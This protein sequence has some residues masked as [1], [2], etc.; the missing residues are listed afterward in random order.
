MIHVYLNPTINIERKYIIEFFEKINTFRKVILT[1]DFNAHSTTWG[2]EI[3]SNVRGNTLDAIFTAGSWIICNDGAHTR[4]NHLSG[5]KSVPDI[6]VVTPVL[7]D[8]VAWQV[9][10]DP[11][12]S[13]HFP[14]TIKIFG[15]RLSRVDNLPKICLKKV[16]WPA[17]RFKMEQYLPDLELNKENFIEKYDTFI[18]KIYQATSFNNQNSTTSSSNRP[19]PIPC[20]WW[21]H[22]CRKARLQRKKAFKFYQEVPSREI[23]DKYINTARETQSIFQRTK[24]ES[25]REF[26]KT[27]KFGDQSKLSKSD[28][29]PIHQVK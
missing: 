13:D 1:G 24:K 20:V 3:D 14:I 25:F 19:V 11:H 18:D 4:I 2:S 28:P 7:K 10:G 12:G 6:T 21:N 27:K 8:R 5:K 23:W 17:F 26:C 29:L 16:D 22:N 15:A 9:D